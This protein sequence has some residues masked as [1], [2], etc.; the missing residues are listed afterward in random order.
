MMHYMQPEIVKNTNTIKKA[1]D[2]GSLLRIN[3]E[4]EREGLP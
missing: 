4:I 1:R 2:F 3:N